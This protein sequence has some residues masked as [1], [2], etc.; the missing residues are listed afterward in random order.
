MRH[1]LKGRKL[2]RNTGHRNSL[3]KNL[4]TNLIANMTAIRINKLIIILIPPTDQASRTG[5]YETKTAANPPK[6]V[7]PISPKLTK[8]A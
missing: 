1:K 8:P 4:S 2:S 7:K 5:E 3:L 6:A